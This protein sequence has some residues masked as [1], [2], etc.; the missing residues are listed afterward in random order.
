VPELWG[1]APGAL[2]LEAVR[3]EPAR[4]AGLDEIAALIG[5]LHACP[6]PPGTASLAERVDFV[7]TYHGVA[8]GELARDLATGGSTALLHGDLHPAN[9]LDA[10]PDR[11]FVA[12]DPRACAGDPAFDAVDWVFWRAQPTAWR[13]RARELATRLGCDEE[14]LW[15]WCAACAAMLAASEAARAGDPARVQALLALVP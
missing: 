4:D 5:A 8:G 2:L 10:G 9:V 12:I 7:F 13:A 11:G 14:R 15:A 3:D 6:I 1:E